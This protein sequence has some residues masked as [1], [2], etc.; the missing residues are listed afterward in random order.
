MVLLARQNGAGAV[1]LFQQQNAG[2]FVGE[3][4]RGEGNLFVAG[5]QDVV[6]KTQR[7]TDEE[8]DTAVHL[9][10][11]LQPDRQIGT[12]VLLAGGR[13]G[14]EAAAVGRGLEQML[15][16]RAMATASG[17]LR[18]TTSFTSIKSSVV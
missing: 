1:E 10:P 16:S 8:G 9:H 15:P 3:G 4:E 11:V 18:P 17:T 6:G 13:Q 7:T 14:D 5:G 12:G 2:Q